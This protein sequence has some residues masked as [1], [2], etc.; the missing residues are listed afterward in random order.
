MKKMSA[1]WFI[2]TG[3]V[4]YLPR[5]NRASLLLPGEGRDC[6]EAGGRATQER[7][8][9]IRDIKISSYVI[10]NP[11]PLLS[12]GGRVYEWDSSSFY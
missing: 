3:R 2:P 10:D 7:L 5:S 11:T 1:E 6:M 8:P 12:P 9:R 4:Y